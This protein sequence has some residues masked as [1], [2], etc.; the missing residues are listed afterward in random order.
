MK[1]SASSSAVHNP[2]TLL[3]KT[4]CFFVQIWIKAALYAIFAIFVCICGL[5]EVLSP[6]KSLGP[7]IAIQQVINP[8]I[9]K[10]NGSKSGK[11]HSLEKITI[12]LNRKFADWRFEELICG[13]PTLSVL[14]LLHCQDAVKF[15]RLSFLVLSANL[16]SVQF[17]NSSV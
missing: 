13:P 14:C 17:F 4:I 7:Q 15:S 9:T 11:C 10:K 1:N 8:Q 5:A 2:K 16:H 3:F 12:F 6:Q